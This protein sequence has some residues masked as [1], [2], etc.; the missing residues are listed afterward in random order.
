V[1]PVLQPA[2]CPFLC[3]CAITTFPFSSHNPHPS[4]PQLPPLPHTSSYM[5]SCRR[6]RVVLTEPSEALLQAVQSDPHKHVFYL[7]QTGEIFDTYEY[8]LLFPPIHSS[9]Y[10]SSPSPLIRA[11]SARMTFYRLKQFQ[12][13]VTGK[14]GL[15]YFQAVE[16]E[17][18]EARTLHSRFSEPLKPAVLKAVQW[19]ASH[20]SSLS[21]TLVSPF[22]LQ[23]SWVALITL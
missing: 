20:S 15:D 11:Y 2:T 6:K 23:R 17:R 13:E 9:S 1:Y 5:P 22:M 12:C 3:R 4:Y 21:I 16:S 8:V 18:H 10:R 14:S 19:R 7:D